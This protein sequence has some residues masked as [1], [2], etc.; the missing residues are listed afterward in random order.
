MDTMYDMCKGA[1]KDLN[2]D[3]KGTGKDQWGY[4]TAYSSIVFQLASCGVHI[5]EKDENDIPNLTA[6]SAKN[7]EIIDKVLEF[8]NDKTTTIHLDQIPTSE[9]GGVSVYEYGNTMFMENRIMFRQTAMVR[10]IQCR[11]M[12][13][14]FGILPYPKYDSEQENYAHGFSYSTP[15]IAIPRYSEDAEAAGAVIE[16]LSY[17]GRTL[18]RPEYYNRVLKGVVARDEESQFCLDIIFDTAF[19]DLGLVLDIGDLDTKLTAM[20]S[21]GTNTFASDYAAVEESAKTQL[22][23]Y[24]DNYESI[25]N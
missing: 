8:Y 17:Y 25:I 6:Y 10:I 7:T 21:K 14:E 5:C 2:D 16:A 3:G 18:V 24:I 19:Y 15:V 11:V 13:E 20:V 22:Q 23:K 1:Y 12:E 9:C 4:L